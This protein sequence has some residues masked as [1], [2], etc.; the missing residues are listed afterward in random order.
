MPDTP[1]PFGRPWGGDIRPHPDRQTS[2]QAEPFSRISFFLARSARLALRYGSRQGWIGRLDKLPVDLEVWDGVRHEAGMLLT[3]V[4]LFVSRRSN[5][6]GDVATDT[7]LRCLLPRIYG[8]IPSQHP[9]YARI[10]CRP[11]ARS[12]AW[13]PSGSWAA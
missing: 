1:F 12:A 7:E 13:L 11:A 5:P 2:S 9:F 8:A 6:A 10:F 3:S 4:L